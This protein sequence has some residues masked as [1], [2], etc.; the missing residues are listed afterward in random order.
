MEFSRQDFL[1]ILIIKAS[2]TESLSEKTQNLSF[3]SEPSI[4]T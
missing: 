1:L 2:K 4:K 3:F